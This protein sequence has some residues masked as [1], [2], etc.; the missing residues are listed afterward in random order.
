MKAFERWMQAL[1]VCLCALTVRWVYRNILQSR[2]SELQAVSELVGIAIL[3]L[4][5][6]SI[7]IVNQNGY[8]KLFYRDMEQFL[9]SPEC[10]MD[11]N[12]QARFIVSRVEQDMMDVSLLCEVLKNMTHEHRDALIQAVIEELMRSQLSD[13][14]KRQILNEF[15]ER[16]IA[17]RDR[18]YIADVDSVI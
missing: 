6:F 18:R 4:V 15:E 2:D 11:L 16:E 17:P 10:A 9:R 12:A 14:M 5:Y 3:C 7:R 13:E 8:R 1:F